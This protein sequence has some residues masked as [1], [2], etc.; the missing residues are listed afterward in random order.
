MG[1]STIQSYCGAQIFEAVG[2]E[3][4]LCRQIFHL[5]TL[6][7]RRG[8]HRRDRA[9][10][11][12]APRARLPRPAG[13]RPHPGSRRPVPVARGR[14][15]PPVQP[16]RRF[17]NC[18]R[19]CRTNDYNVFKEYAALINDQSSQLAT[20][21][22]LLEFKFADEPVPLEEV[23]PVEVDRAALQDR[24]HV[25][26]LDQ[27]GS[28]RGAGDCHEPHRRQEQ[29]RRRRRRPGPLHPGCQRRLAQQRHQAGGLGPFWRDQRL[30]GQRPRAADQDGAGRQTRR[31]RAAARHARSIPGSPKCA[32]R[33]PASG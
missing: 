1:I 10:S 28:A 6:A 4:G 27:Q 25:L 26:R 9:R 8:R 5:D 17:T 32:T 21:R 22:G 11:R 33:P 24:G 23:E 18:S 16:A 12:H 19:P 3:P 29:H 15:A 14:R 13:Q 20:L 30:S 7:H 2:S 31:R